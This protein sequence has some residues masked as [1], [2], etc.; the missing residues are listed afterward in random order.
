MILDFRTFLEGGRGS[1]TKIS[2][3]GAGAGGQAQA[4]MHAAKPGTPIKTPPSEFSP[5]DAIPAGF[6]AKGG[7]G[8]ANYKH[9]VPPA[10]PGMMGGGIRPP[11]QSV[12]KLKGGPFG[13]GGPG[14]KMKKK[15]KAKMKK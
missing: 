8:S 12:G 5:S 6:I 9:P 7:P 10:K 15:M 2:A 1:G 11:Y 13:G 14:S 4:G 3:T